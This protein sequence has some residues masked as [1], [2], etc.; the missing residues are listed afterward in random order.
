MAE[1][2]KEKDLLNEDIWTVLEE[3]IRDINLLIKQISNIT[4]VIIE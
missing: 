3:E 2:K 1:V 4:P